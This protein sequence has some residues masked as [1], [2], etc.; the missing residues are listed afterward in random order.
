VNSAMPFLRYL[1]ILGLVLGLAGCGRK[2]PLQLPPM[3]NP[4][5]A[6]TVSH[7]HTAAS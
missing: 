1:L 6:H 4:S 2:T 5:P 3:S 7:S